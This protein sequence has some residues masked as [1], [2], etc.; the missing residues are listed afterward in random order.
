MAC[1]L[2]LLLYFQ[3]QV[4]RI[5]IL[6]QSNS[7]YAFTHLLGAEQ[8]HQPRTLSLSLQETIK[9]SSIVL[10]DSEMPTFFQNLLPEAENRRLLALARGC[11]IEDEFELLAAAGADLIGA[12]E[13][14]PFPMME[15]LPEATESWLASFPVSSS[16]RAEVAPPIANAM[17]LSGVVRK[18]SVVK[19]GSCFTANRVGRPGTYILKLPTERHPD[20]VRLEWM[21]FVLLKSIGVPCAEVELVKVS[22]V[23]LPESIVFPELL[24]V[25]RFDRD[26][27][28]RRVHM[29]EF[30]QIFGY[31]PKAKYGKG[32]AYDFTRMVRVLHEYARSP[33]EQVQALVN[34]LVAFILLGN[35]DAH[36]KNWAVIYP[37]GF[38]PELS[39]AYDVVSVSS[40]FATAHS[41]DYALNRAIDNVMSKVTWKELEAMLKEGGVEDTAGL[42]GCAQELVLQAQAH[43]PV[44][45][46]VAPERMRKEVLRRLGGGVR[47]AVVRKSV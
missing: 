1:H 19:K 2:E 18:F 8:E 39:P 9:S 47:L 23:E 43:W 33:L 16:I 30:A 40:F 14:R 35:T 25:K 46:E 22:Q 38:H 5:G 10:L 34:Q 32:L 3:N 44:L 36:L 41:Q 31:A 42:I 11:E 20:L 45:L 13:V 6:S 7:S 15:A 27:E 28:G 4:Q 12:L 21:G 29:E 37:D 24:A 17:A 26:T